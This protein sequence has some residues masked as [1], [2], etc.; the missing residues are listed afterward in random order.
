MLYPKNFEQK[1][2]FDVIRKMISKNCLSEQGAGYAEKIRFVTDFEQL[3]KLLDQTEEFRQLL[4]DKPDF[5]SQDYFDLTPELHRIKIEGSYIELDKLFDLK[6]SLSTILDVVSYFSVAEASKIYNLKSIID[7]IQVDPSIPKTID[8]LVDEK[9][10]IRDNASEKL[11]EI[12][13]KIQSKLSAVDRKINQ[14]L[15]AAKQSGWVAS[16]VEVSIRDGRPVIPIPATHKRKIKGFILDESATGQTVFI[17]PGEVLELNNEIRELQ[18]AERRE[19]IQIL[20]NFSAFVRPYIPGLIEAYRFIGLIDFIR[21]KAKLAHQ[22]KAVKPVLND[23]SLINWKKAMHPLLY[24]HHQKLNKKVVPLD[25]SLNDENRI[26]VISGPNA[27]GKSVCLKTVALLQYM[28]QCGLLIPVKEDSEAGIFTDMFIDIGDEQSLEND[29]STYSSHL[30]NMKNFV[31]NSNKRSIFF[32]DE[33]GTGTEPQLGGAIAEAILDNLNQKKVFGVITTHYA[34]L[35]VLA[36]EGNGIINGA[37]LF[38]TEKI[39][40][41]Y[42]LKIGQPGSSFAFEIARKIG[43]PSKILNLAEKKTGKKQLDFEQQ[44]QQLD[45]EKR[46]LQK[47]EEE[48]RLADSF[49]SEM[50]DKYEKLSGEL[51]TGKEEI[52]AKARQEALNLIQSSN[53]LIEKTIKDIR[54]SQADKAR[55]KELRRKVEE[56]AK[57]IS[58]TIEPK[59]KVKPSPSKSAKPDETAKSEKQDEKLKVGDLVKVPDQNI[60]GEITS[61]IDDEVVIAFNSI[62]FRTLLSKVEKIPD[63]AIKPLSRKHKTSYSGILDDMN[64]KLSNFKLQLDVRGNRGDE[65]LEMV[66]QYIDDAIL[67]NIREVRILHGKGYGILRNLIHEYLRS[68]PEIKQFKDEHIEQGGH[69][70]TIVILK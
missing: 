41:L 11:K 63:N 38:D 12:R 40:P 58:H 45:I 18:N 15:K 6:S 51:E 2:E 56:K 36:R 13:K 61:I 9:G 46:E 64:D 66:R 19:M 14:A 39:E 47:R 67:L 30:L 16:D 24:L 68:I 55:T 43:F 62:T 17:E 60:Q 44:L 27:G 35:K 59:K 54:E 32:I 20:K 21:A 28:L 69:G 23:K 65:A 26:L 49:L 5:P 70:I 57:E 10:Q 4:L 37:M 33:F 29:L 8:R 22:I 42:E 50:I 34:N 52:I 7:Q 48:L 1:I 53:R 25:I 3:K 31:L